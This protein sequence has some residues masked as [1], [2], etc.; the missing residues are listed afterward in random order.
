[1][2]VFAAAMAWVEAAVVLY[3]RTLVDRLEPY[4]PNP[5]PMATGLGSAELVRELATLVMLASVGWLAGRSTRGR[6]AYAVLAFGVWD[7]AYYGFLRP[8]TGWPRTLLDWDILFLL[9]LPW[10][11]PVL[12]PALIAALM[13]LGGSLIVLGEKPGKRLC[14]RGAGLVLAGLG[15]VVALYVFMADAIA[16]SD[17]GGKALRELL[18]TEFNWPLFLVAFALMTLPVVELAVNWLRFEPTFRSAPALSPAVTAKTSPRHELPS[19][20]RF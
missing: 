20:S 11:G 12:A 7:I 9:P 18:P 3:L 13:V 4:Q 14:P 1:V 6:V 5:L 8:L 16:V 2:V 17:Q 19:S 15:G 10:W